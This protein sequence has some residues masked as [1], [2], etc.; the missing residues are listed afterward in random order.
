MLNS[1]SLREKIF[2][3][4]GII[5]LL[6]AAYYFYFYLPLSEELTRLENT[7]EN[8]QTT[9]KNIEKSI[10]DFDKVKEKHKEL[11]EKIVILAEKE[12]EEEK[13]EYNVTTTDL[14]KYFNNIIEVTDV[15]MRT[16]RPSE[17]EEKVALNFS[18]NGSFYEIVNFFDEIDKFQPNI[19]YESLS[20]NRT[21]D[22]LKSDIT[23]IFPKPVV[24][25]DEGENE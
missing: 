4:I 5:L 25:G 10:S 12:E 1:L 15:E 7:L 9:V 24:E 18:H 6:L 21:E 14:L 22:E 16:F 8:K 13:K 11:S 3:F 2:M 19:S 17:D 20:L 23:L